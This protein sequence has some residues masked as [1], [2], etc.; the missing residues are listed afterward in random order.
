[1]F[2]VVQVLIYDFPSDLTVTLPDQPYKTPVP[3]SIG[4][5]HFTH[6]QKE[7]HASI[8]RCCP[9]QVVDRHE[10]HHGQA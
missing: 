4:I 3:F 10:V 2:A 5:T 1:M 9:D 7:I 8:G 6:L